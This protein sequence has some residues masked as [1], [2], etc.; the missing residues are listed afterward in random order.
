MIAYAIRFINYSAGDEPVVVVDRPSEPTAGELVPLLRPQPWLMRATLGVSR[1]TGQRVPSLP[2][3]EAL[4]MQGFVE[5]A[6]LLLW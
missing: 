5:R 6:P 4:P 2:L 3:L 1:L